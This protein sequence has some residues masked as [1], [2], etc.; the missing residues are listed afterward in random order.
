MKLPLR[1]IARFAGRVQVVVVQITKKILSRKI[2]YRNHYPKLLI[3]E[4][5]LVKRIIKQSTS[6]LMKMVHV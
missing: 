6:Y 1:E 3:T 4:V 5:S 2:K